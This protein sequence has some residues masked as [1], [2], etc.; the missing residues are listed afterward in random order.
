MEADQEEPPLAAGEGVERR[1]HQVLGHVVVQRALV[2][3]HF[4]LI[5][6]AAALGKWPVEELLRLASQRPLEDWRQPPL[7]LVFLTRHQDPVIV[8]AEHLAE[9]G[10]V[11]QERARR[12]DVLDQAP[13][14]REGVLHRRRRQQQHRR[15]SEEPAHAV[16]HQRF[17]RGLVVGAV[18]VVAFVEPG[19]DLVGLVDDDQVER[20]RRRQRLGATLAAGKFASDEVDAGRDEVA[21]VLG[22]LDSEQVQQLVLPLP[23]Q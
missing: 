16:R 23:D 10:D 22:C 21:A 18:A 14:L 20:R 4:V 11:A 3:G 12:L 8:R 5:E 9:G 7:Q 15:G 1:L 13:Q 17:L 6:P 19:E 2:A